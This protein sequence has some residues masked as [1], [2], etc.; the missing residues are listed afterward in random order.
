VSIPTNAAY[1]TSQQRSCG[2][3]NTPASHSMRPCICLHPRLHY[4]CPWCHNLKL[5]LAVPTHL[6]PHPCQTPHWPPPPEAAPPATAAAPVHAWLQAVLHGRLQPT[7][8]QLAAAL[9]AHQQWPCKSNAGSISHKVRLCLARHTP[10]YVVLILHSASTVALHSSHQVP[11]KQMISRL[12][13]RLQDKASGSTQPQIDC[14]QHSAA[15]LQAS[16]QHMTV[17]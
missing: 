13:N 15:Y 3:L 12:P 17:L 16:Y 8:P 9:T 10:T 6:C 5:D 7:D 2:R 4:S 1:S 11:F 14:T